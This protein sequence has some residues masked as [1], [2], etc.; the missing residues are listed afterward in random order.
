MT[1][2]IVD[3][4]EPVQVHEHQRELA[5]FPIRALDRTIEPVFQQH[6]I[7]EF[8]EI[9]VQRQVGQFLIGLGE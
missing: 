1:V 2:G 9:V 4:L 7:R 6:T 3:R 5:I 8:R